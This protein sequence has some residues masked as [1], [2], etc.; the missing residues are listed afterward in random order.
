MYLF[1]IWWA[2]IKETDEV[3]FELH[4]KSS[5]QVN[6]ILDNISH[7]NFSADPKYKTSLKL[8]E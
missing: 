3:Q 5:S 6:I 7:V 4:T 2:Q 1:F 8:D